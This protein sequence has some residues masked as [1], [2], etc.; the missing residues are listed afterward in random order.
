MTQPFI[1]VISQITYRDETVPVG[2]VMAKS[3]FHEDW[4]WMN[5]V[6]L[7]FVVEQADA[8]KL[9]DERLGENTQN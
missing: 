4:V 7:G 9:S 8:G 1:R 2:T 3:D 5:L 6:Q